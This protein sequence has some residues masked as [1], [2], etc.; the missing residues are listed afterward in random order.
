MIWKFVLGILIGFVA[1]LTEPLVSVFGDGWRQMISYTLG[2]LVTAPVGLLMTS[3]FEEVEDPYEKTF[4]IWSNSFLAV[5][6]GTLA[7]WLFV[8]GQRSE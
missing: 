2:V 4:L 3:E 1:H 6:L 8:N 5:G 7:G